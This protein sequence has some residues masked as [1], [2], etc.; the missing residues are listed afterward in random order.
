ML[1]S[2]LMHCLNFSFGIDEYRY[3]TEK[4][5][6]ASTLKKLAAS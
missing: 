6:F 2:L 4:F 3:H 1:V 5:C